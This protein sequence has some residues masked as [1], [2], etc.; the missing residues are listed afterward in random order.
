MSRTKRAG[1]GP[2]GWGKQESVDDNHFTQ[3]EAENYEIPMR[4]LAG[5]PQVSGAGGWKHSD[6]GW[7]PPSDPLSSTSTPFT[8]DARPRL[9]ITFR[10]KLAG[11]STAQTTAN[12]SFF[13]RQHPRRRPPEGQHSFAAMGPPAGPTF[14][15]AP[16]SAARPPLPLCCFEPETAPLAP[17]QSPHPV[18]DPS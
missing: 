7:G 5:V 11:F 18:P 9:A 3:I 14:E 8:Y 2:G 10:E 6:P 4:G 15:K 12:P 1:E 17:L 16:P 13:P